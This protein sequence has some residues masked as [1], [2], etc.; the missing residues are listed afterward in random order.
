[1]VRAKWL[2]ISPQ[3]VTVRFNWSNCSHKPRHPFLSFTGVFHTNKVM[4][5]VSA[6][7]L[8][9][10]AVKKLWNHPARLLLLAALM[11]LS[12]GPL[13]WTFETELTG[14]EQVL[15]G[16]TDC[17]QLHRVAPFVHF[18]VTQIDV[19]WLV[20][21]GLLSHRLCQTNAATRLF[22]EIRSKQLMQSW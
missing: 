11:Y 13:V 2:P 4:A 16:A 5:Q 7:A 14:V 20:F 9:G 21:H 6:L 18:P 17:H 8:L 22:V 1:M 12:T 19:T 15:V 10:E 3:I